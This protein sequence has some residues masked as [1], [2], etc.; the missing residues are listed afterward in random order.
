MA[1][2]SRYSFL[3][4]PLKISN[5]FKTITSRLDMAGFVNCIIQNELNEFLF[6]KKDSK[7][8]HFPGK[9]VLFGGA[10]EENESS[11]EAIRRELLDEIGIS[12]KPSFL[13]EVEYTITGKKIKGI[14]FFSKFSENLSHIKLS[15]G[16]GFAFFSESETDRND[17]RLDDK[18]VIKRFLNG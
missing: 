10:I 18:K 1:L 15:E 11:E 6:Q 2:Y 7:Y 5:A 16:N 17:V 8:P 13:F 14:T 12:F 4:I 9:W 3:Y